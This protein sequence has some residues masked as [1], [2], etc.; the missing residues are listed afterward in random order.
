M[1]MD[2]TRTR[3]ES[4]HHYPV[5]T[6]TNTTDFTSSPNKRPTPRPRAQTYEITSP[7][8]RPWNQLAQTY[9]WVVQQEYA[10]LEKKNKKTEKWVI[11]QLELFPDKSNRRKAGAGGTGPQR[12]KTWEELMD[13]YEV[14]ADIWMRQEAETRRAVIER[15]K[16]K[17]RAIEKDIKRI[18]ARVQQKKEK[19]RQRLTEERLQ[20]T[21]AQKVRAKQERAR[22]NVASMDVW[23]AYEA[24]WAS[25]AGCSEPLTFRT[26]PWPLVSHPSS[27]KDIIPAGITAFLLSPLHSQSQTRKDRIRGA[28]LRWHPDRFRKYL[29]KVVEEDR[30]LVEEGVGIVVRC[31]N[32]QME[33]ETRVSRHSMKENNA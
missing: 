26:I 33:R 22:S 7:V 10:K 28:L 19:E 32:E 11:E 27:T 4:I 6:R 13:G 17:A 25:I 30:E 20:A 29:L 2:Y 16:E 9:T 12:R 24:Q 21:E 3:T 5:I 1:T 18:Q 23:R 31:L 15:E 14:E 8:D